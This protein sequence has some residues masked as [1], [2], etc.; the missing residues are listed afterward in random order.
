MFPHALEIEAVAG[1]ETDAANAIDRQFK[2]SRQHKYE[3]FPGVI[4]GAAALRARLQVPL[5]AIHHPVAGRDRADDDSFAEIGEPLPLVA[6]HGPHD[7]RLRRGAGVLKW[8]LITVFLV[9]PIF[10]YRHHVTDKGVFPKALTEI[11]A[12]GAG[13]SNLH[14]GQAKW[15]PYLAT[16]LGVLIVAVGAYLAVN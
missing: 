12:D 14:V 10:L 5:L 15:L 6:P 9:V 3:F 4:V 8:G 1:E 2:A 7:G 13:A 16:G 11:A